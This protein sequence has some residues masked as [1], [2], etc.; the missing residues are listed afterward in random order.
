M[1]QL[2]HTVIRASAGTGK[3]HAL[4]NRILT[5]LLGGVKPERIIALTFNRTAAGEIFDTVIGRLAK[6]SRSGEEA[7]KLA[8][9]LREVRG[10]EPLDAAKCRETLR[11]LLLRMHLSP[12]GTI[13]SFFVKIIRAF[14]FEHGISGEFAIAGENE[15]RLQRERIL[16]TLLQPPADEAEAR[17]QRGFFE[18]FKRATFGREEKRLHDLLADF[19]D[20]YH[21]LYLDAADLARW[22]GRFRSRKCRFWSD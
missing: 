6:A 20:E 2:P 12:I 17:E 22:G 10:R 7:A 4:T 3:T 15:Q 16:R 19:V 9:E 5:L 14:P 21:Q 1:N 11:R 8:E 18:S 13:D